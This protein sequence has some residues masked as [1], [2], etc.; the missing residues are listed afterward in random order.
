MSNFLDALFFFVLYHFLH[1]LLSA[2]WFTYKQMARIY[3]KQVGK[4]PLYVEFFMIAFVPLTFPA[5]LAVQY[6]NLIIFIG[7][8]LTLLV[9]WY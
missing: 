9:L 2:Q 8:V 1:F 5:K 7:W 4:W 6:Q 3:L